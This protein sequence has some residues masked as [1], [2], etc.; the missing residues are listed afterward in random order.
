[1]KIKP[2]EDEIWG[3]IGYIKISQSRYKTLKCLS[4]EN[5]MPTEISKKTRLTSAQVSVAL[6][7]MKKKR[8]VR[9]MNED[10]AKGRIYQCTDL[11]LM[12]IE[13]LEKTGFNP[14]D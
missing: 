7:D 14:E 9:C 12:I 6:K 8:I 13:T 2:T 1:M 11:G 3:N 10:A 4:R 5:L